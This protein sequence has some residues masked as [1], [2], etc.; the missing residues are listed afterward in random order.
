MVVFGGYAYDGSVS[1]YL[2]D[3]FQLNLSTHVWVELNASG[4]NPDGRYGH[5]ACNYNNKMIVFGGFGGLFQR[6]L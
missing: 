6:F 4:S 1:Y 5:V 3:L 2:N